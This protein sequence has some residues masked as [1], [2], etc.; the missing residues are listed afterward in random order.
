MSSKMLD[1][2]KLIN[3]MPRP[4]GGGMQR[5]PVDGATLGIFYGKSHGFP[6]LAFLTHDK[7]LEIKSTSQIKVEQWK[8]SSECN[9]T[10]FTLQSEDARHEFDCLA[11]DLIAVAYKAGSEQEAILA[12]K[13]CFMRWK[14]LFKNSREEMPLETYMGL[15]G[16]L[17]ILYSVLSRVYG[18]DISVHGWGGPDQTA[19]DFAIGNDW[20]EVKTISASKNVVQISSL[21][22]LDSEAEGTLCVIKVERMPAQFDN[23][24]CTIRQLLDKILGTLK[25]E[26]VKAEL[27]EKIDQ[28]GF[29]ETTE[30]DRRFNVCASSYYAVRDGFPRLTLRSVPY[31]EIVGVVYQI[32]LGMISGFMKEI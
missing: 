16:E 26:E 17:Y 15:F 12:V 2:S 13:N 10:C 31:N 6:C 23:G 7:P 18:L 9:W 25:S 8:E 21:T 14:M 11:E 1:F 28:C 3:N 29:H 22:Q 19:K 32:D 4:D 30:D 20:Y 27:L 24:M 5:L